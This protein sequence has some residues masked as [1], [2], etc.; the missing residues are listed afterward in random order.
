MC[1]CFSRRN[2][3]YFALKIGPLLMLK[4]G[5]LWQ[6]D[7]AYVLPVLLRFEGHPEVDQ[8]VI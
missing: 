3:F 6:A 8:Q 4:F 2:Y 5:G 7:E 1:T